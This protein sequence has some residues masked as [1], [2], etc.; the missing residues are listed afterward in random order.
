[1]AG[2]RICTPDWHTQ[3]LPPNM[4]RGR[5]GV[6]GITYLHMLFF[7]TATHST[8]LGGFLPL[9]CSTITVKHQCFFSWLSWLAQHLE[10]WNL[11][12]LKRIIGERT[13]DF[14]ALKNP[15]IYMN[16]RS[17]VFQDTQGTQHPGTA[18]QWM[19]F[20]LLQRN[21]ILKSFVI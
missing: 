4:Q 11:F 1:M 3:H 19:A 10:V 2:G 17:H 12:E 20:C 15:S 9:N 14:W 5:G 8:T 13:W 21:L 7:P 16:K 6:Q 18:F